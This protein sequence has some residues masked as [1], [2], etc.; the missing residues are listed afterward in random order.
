MSILK[1]DKVSKKVSDTGE[2]SAETKCYSKLNYSNIH[3][4]NLFGKA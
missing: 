3:S 2:K 4:H 1:L